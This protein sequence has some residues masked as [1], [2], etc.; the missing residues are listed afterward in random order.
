MKRF[1]TTM[2]LLF[3]GILIVL[4]F[5]GAQLKVRTAF[6]VP[7]LTS[8]NPVALGAN[9]CASGSCHSGTPAPGGSV[10]VN[11]P[12]GL[13][14]SPGTVQHLSVT[15]TDP[16]Q[17]RV[18]FELTARLAS[19]FQAGAFSA[20]GANANLG[21]NGVP[22]VQGLGNSPTFTFD[23]TPPA[24]GAGPVTFY[25]T[26]LAGPCCSGDGLYTNMY[27]LT[28]AAAVT[29]DFSL[30]ASPT[31]LTVTQG[32]SGTST[33]SVSKLN[34]FAGSVALMASGLPSGVTA[35]FSP[36]STTGT[37]TL[38][39][40]ASSTATAGTSTVTITGTSGS[41]SHTATVSLTVNGAATPDFS[42]SAS[43][44]SL[45]IAQGASGTSTIT[46]TPSGGFSSSTVSFAPPGLPTGVTASFSPI[47]STGKSTLTLSASSSAASLTVGL[48]ITGTSGSLTHSTTV[49]L[50]VN[51]A[52]TSGT[53]TASP[54][55]LTF[56]YQMGGRTP[57]SRTLAISSTGGS[58]S[59]T[60]LET[61]PW[62]SI[63]PAIGGSTPADIR[64]SVNPAGMAPGTYGAQINISAPNRKTTTVLV[65]LNITSG[66]GGGTPGG[67]FAQTYMY[68]PTQSGGLAAAWVDNLGT[69]P[70]N[71]S[72]PR[73]QGLVLAKNATAPSGS[74]TGAVITNVQGSLT[75]LGFDYR[76]GGQCTATSPRFVVVT[77]SS[78]THVVGGCSKGTITAAPTM[79]WKR[80]R[81][82]LTDSSIQTSPSILPG[83]SVSS[84][85]LVMDQG[86]ETGSSAAG[87]LV[88]I[89]NIEVNGTLV[90]KGSSTSTSR[91]D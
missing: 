28:P 86:P 90:G 9:T 75:E 15:V 81:F 61:D 69:T 63:T 78:G 16:N 73:N 56:N 50:T 33:I 85:T 68:D 45:T 91:D 37:S 10:V 82:K 35:T 21:T 70:H 42:L 80:V 83:D 71:A 87:G 46:I 1:R 59:F 29:P 41:L 14:Y 55:A 39:L 62:L 17:T 2:F 49:S 20:P 84:I 52:T 74:L 64:A 7:R 23:W 48:T 12:S 38:T 60:A 26:G 57:S 65:T 25:L 89:D 88:V 30:S 40:A 53:L 67:M 34:S 72:D 19:A 18:G 36:T 44:S 5:F 11:F 8:Q 79:G 43:P 58:T 32:L 54:A 31:G 3:T 4:V 6:A 76:D 24:Q 77:A 22:V 13:T 51:P 27:T 66:S 47:S